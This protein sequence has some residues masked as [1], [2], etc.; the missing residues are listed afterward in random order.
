MQESFPKPQSPEKKSKEEALAAYRILVERGFTSPDV[1]DS[2]DPDVAKANT[3]FEKWQTGLGDD[4]RSNFEKTK[5]Y[6]DAGFTDPS[7]LGDVLGWLYQDAAD[8]EKD[9]GNPEL[10][11][12]RK[13]YA[14]EMRK[15]RKM[16]GQP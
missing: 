13:E 15:I 10:V 9:A 3:L 5:F 8:L 6:V 7:Y 1:L 16:L 14:D 11:Q 4:A 2:D 12:L